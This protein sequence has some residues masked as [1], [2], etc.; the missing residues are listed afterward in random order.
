ME[1]MMRGNLNLVQQHCD[2]AISGV[3]FEDKVLV[4]H[5]LDILLK[6]TLFEDFFQAWVTHL[7]VNGVQK[8]LVQR[9]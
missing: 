4:F 8:L 5:L 6:L 3:T 1:H 9:L 7:V 2:A